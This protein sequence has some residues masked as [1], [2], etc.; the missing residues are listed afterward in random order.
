[1]SA[2]PT[3]LNGRVLVELSGAYEH[4]DL[5]DK[6]Y[7]IK[8]SG[9]VRAVSDESQLTVMNKKIYFETFSDGFEEQGLK[10]AF[11][12]YEDIDGYHE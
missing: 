5:P 1:M 6:Q 9:I 2:Y 8:T 12:K 4:L 11:I 3:P 10:L 7:A